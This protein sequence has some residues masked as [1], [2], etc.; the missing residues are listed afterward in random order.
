MIQNAQQQNAILNGQW[1]WFVPPGLCIAAIGT[2]VGLI[3]FGI[4]EVASPRLRSAR[5]V[6]RKR[7][8]RTAAR[9]AARTGSEAAA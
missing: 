3:N 8:S 1:W 2:A 6:V 5:R 4:D 9:T 7:T